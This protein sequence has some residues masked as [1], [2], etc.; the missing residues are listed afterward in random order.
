[1]KRRK[2]IKSTAAA[3]ALPLILNGMPI[4]ALRKS[5]LFNAINDKDDKI[6]V[7][8]ELNGGNDGLNTVI[9]IDQIDQL[10]N[11][12]S[13]ILIPESQIL[14]LTDKTGLHPVMTGMKSLYDNAK[15]NVVQNVGYPNQNRSH[16]RSTDIWKSGS[17][18]DEYL[19]TGWLGRYFDLKYPGFPNAYPNAECTDPFS[20]TVGS[21]VSETCQGMGGNFSMALI[22]PTQLFTLNEGAEG[23]ANQN[24]CYGMELAFLR[25]ALLQTNSYVNV[26]TQANTSGTNQVTYPDDNSLATQLKLVAKL[27]SGGLKSKVYVTNLS[28]FDTHA[29]QTDSMDPTTGSHAVLLGQVSSAIAA[30]QADLAAQGLEERVIGM[31][32]SE[33]GRQIKSNFSTGTDHGTAAPLFLFGTCVKPGITGN[34]PF[35]PTQLYNQEGVA[36]D[37]DFRSI[38]GTILKDWF[39]MSDLDISAILFSGW[40]YLPLIKDCT[41][42]TFDPTIDQLEVKLYPNPVSQNAHIEFYAESEQIRICVFNALGFEVKLISDQKFSFGLHRIDFNMD[43][44]PAGNYYLRID[45]KRAS[46]TKAFVRI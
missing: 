39:K 40:Q 43:G 44:L 2:F 33:F 34:N 16:F 18:A 12:R 13:N 17:D 11:A 10:A 46:V 19:P 37:I 27:I 25:N 29:D 32:F 7:L 21:L 3:V 30:F 35:I 4:T 45:S 6:L 22:D 23:N 15:L 28:G 20:I 42:A 14:K 24:T 1:M 26:V 8:V 41:T 9:P 36:M 31:T 38:Y 5:S